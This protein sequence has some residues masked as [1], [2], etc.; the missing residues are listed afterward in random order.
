LPTSK[1]DKGDEIDIKRDTSALP[2]IKNILGSF[3]IEQR[4]H[5][6]YLEKSLKNWQKDSYFLPLPYSGF[7]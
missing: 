2:E 3:V 7:V 1:L 4:E 6:K 5:N